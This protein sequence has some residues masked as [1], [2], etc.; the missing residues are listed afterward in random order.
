MMITVVEAKVAEENWPLLEQAYRQGPQ[1]LP[2]GLE[3]SFLV[4]SLENRGQWQI[5]SVWS[6]MPSLQKLQQSIESGVI[7]RGVL[8]FREAGAEPTHT[9]YEVVQ[10]RASSQAA[11]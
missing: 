8:I 1:Q 5:I 11:S 4:H 9:V 2:P 7:P 3:R 6:G 10:E